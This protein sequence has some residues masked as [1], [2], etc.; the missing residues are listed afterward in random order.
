VAHEALAVRPP[1]LCD[2]FSGTASDSE[3]E[4]TWK[5]ASGVQVTCYIIEV[6]VW[7][8]D[9]YFSTSP[10]GSTYSEWVRLEAPAGTK[11]NVY[12]FVRTSRSVKVKN[13]TPGNNATFQV[14]GWY[15]GGDV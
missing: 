8:N 11:A 9:L 4:H 12:S 14:V 6:F 3:T 15:Y 1:D 7:D 10:D 5:D 13:Y 2:T